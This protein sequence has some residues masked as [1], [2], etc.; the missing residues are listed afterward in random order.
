MNWPVDNDSIIALI[1]QHEGGYVNNSDDK[2][3]PT[4]M[5]V[6]IESL[7]S[8]RG[9]VCTAQ[10][11]QNLSLKEASALYL[12]KYLV[13]P[14]FDQLADIKLRAAMVDFGVLFGPVRA[15]QALQMVI[16]VNIDGF[17]GPQ[18]LAAANKILDSRPI[19][20][21]LSVVRINK[22]TDRV[23]N[24]SSQLQFF[25]GWINRTLSFIE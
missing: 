3:G 9:S 11:I 4:N 21:Q 7:G 2:G 15:S 23:M 8:F 19:I 16:K 22:H 17:L 12:N 14:N 13:T 5:G 1:I 6:T 18:S 25:R 20:N 24:D 10:D